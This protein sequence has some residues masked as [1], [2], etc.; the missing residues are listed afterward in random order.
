M[1]LV[2]Q[3]PKRPD[4]EAFLRLSPSGLAQLL[5]HAQCS[6]SSCTDST[7][8]LQEQSPKHQAMLH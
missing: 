3:V 4:I 1:M 7:A 6:L 8:V 2:W 5:C